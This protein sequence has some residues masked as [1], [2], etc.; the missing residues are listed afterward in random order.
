MKY[1]SLLYCMLMPLKWRIIAEAYII[2]SVCMLQH[3]R[4]FI[5]YVF[6]EQLRHRT[7]QCVVNFPPPPYSPY[8][9]LPK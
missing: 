6:K 2:M 4:H 5:T 1:S 7:L 3:V 9:Y 8:K